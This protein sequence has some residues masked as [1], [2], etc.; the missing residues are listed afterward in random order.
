M[1]LDPINNSTDESVS[2][3]LRLGFL[4]ADPIDDME[5]DSDNY[6]PHVIDWDELEAERRHNL[7]GR[8]SHDLAAA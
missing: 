3:V 7:I 2:T 1:H 4:L 6:G 5:T 8:P